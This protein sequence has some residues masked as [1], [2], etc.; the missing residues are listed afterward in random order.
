MLFYAIPLLFDAIPL[1]FDA[2]PLLFYAM[3][4]QLRNLCVHRNRVGEGS[5]NS[6]FSLLLPFPVGEGGCPGEVHRTH[7]N[8]V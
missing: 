1:L 6:N 5:Q 2:M 4:L 8:L 7:V 3:P